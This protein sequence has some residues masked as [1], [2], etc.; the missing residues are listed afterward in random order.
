MLPSSSWA[1]IASGCTDSAQSV[2]WQL[3][4]TVKSTAH[5]NKPYKNGI[6]SV[7]LQVDQVRVQTFSRLL[8]LSL[9]LRHHVQR[10]LAQQSMASNAA[11]PVFWNWFKYFTSLAD[12]LGQQSVLNRDEL[13]RALA[14][15][16]LH[17]PVLWIGGWALELY[18]WGTR[19][20]YDLH[21]LAFML[22]LARS[23][24]NVYTDYRDSL[25]Y[26]IIMGFSF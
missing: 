17:R 8:L 14:S 4:M 3:L 13:N 10:G 12:V 24:Y 20:A 15:S 6:H 26:S 22:V 25:F 19:G 18:A 9:H 7:W 16:M 21:W 11:M 2:A 1:R 23:V 5:F